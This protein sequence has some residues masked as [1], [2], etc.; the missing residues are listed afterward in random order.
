MV[1]TT[2]PQQE[3]FLVNSF[4]AAGSLEPKRSRSLGGV[5]AKPEVTDG[6]GMGRVPLLPSL[7]ALQGGRW[8][9]TAGG[10]QTAARGSWRASFTSLSFLHSTDLLRAEYLIS[11]PFISSTDWTG[12]HWPTRR[13]IRPRAQQRCFSKY[14]G[15]TATRLALSRNRFPREKGVWQRL[16]A[17]Q[18]PQDP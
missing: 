11:T 4:S 8:F 10:G 18:P 5:A 13:P 15:L 2:K 1:S 9:Q 6:D 17:P 12:Q 14:G 7:E 3:A 16:P